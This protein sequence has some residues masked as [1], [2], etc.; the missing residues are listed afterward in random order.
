MIF[1][2]YLKDL[3]RFLNIQIDIQMIFKGYL[4]DIQIDIQMIFKGYLKDI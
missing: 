4:K 1:K 2:W 3:K